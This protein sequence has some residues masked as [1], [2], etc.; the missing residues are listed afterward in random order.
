[1]L[2]KNADGPSLPLAALGRSR[3]AVIGGACRNG[4]RCC[5]AAAGSTQVMGY[6]RASRWC[7]P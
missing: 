6:G 1:V 7:S 3:I 2:L 5:P 4:G